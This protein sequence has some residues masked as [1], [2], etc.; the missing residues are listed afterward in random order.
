MNI[1]LLICRGASDVQDFPQ[2]LHES[3][4]A[5]MRRAISPAQPCPEG[6]RGPSA[7]I[8]RG[9]APT[10]VLPRRNAR[11]AAQLPGPA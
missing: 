9:A 3:Q 6:G 11:V 7:L 10:N 1:A 2:C 8:P 4:E 5:A